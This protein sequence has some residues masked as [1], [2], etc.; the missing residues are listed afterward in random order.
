ML[1]LICDKNI[2]NLIM[3]LVLL[4]LD[5]KIITKSN[6][7]LTKKLPNNLKSKSTS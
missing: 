7:I 6:T 4:I 3:H 1:I 5:S 2:N